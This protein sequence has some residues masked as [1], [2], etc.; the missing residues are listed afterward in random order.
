MIDAPIPAGTLCTLAGAQVRVYATIEV[1]RTWDR[2][3]LCR[4]FGQRTGRT[5]ARRDQLEPIGGAR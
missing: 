5:L 3:Y 4:P 2:T 1:G